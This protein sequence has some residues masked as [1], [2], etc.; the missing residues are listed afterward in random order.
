M[1]PP[2]LSSACVI[3]Q[4][5]APVRGAEGHRW[6]VGGRVGAP[7]S[8]SRATLRDATALALHIVA[9]LLSSMMR[10]VD[11]GGVNTE[12]FLPKAGGVKPNNLILS[13]ARGRASIIDLIIMCRVC[14][15]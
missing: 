15:E 8:A 11:G 13:I 14:M 2:R 3:R 4:A 7:P 9:V 1:E 5:G 6:L 12:L 10:V